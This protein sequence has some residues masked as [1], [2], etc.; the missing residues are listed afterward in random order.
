MLQIL[1]LHNL[2]KLLV[3]IFVSSR[4][5]CDDGPRT[6]LAPFSPGPRRYIRRYIQCSGEMF[7]FLFWYFPSA[8]F[9]SALVSG[10]VSLSPKPDRYNHWWKRGREG[11]KKDIS[12]YHGGVHTS[13]LTLGDLCTL[14]ALLLQVLAH[15]VNIWLWEEAGLILWEEEG[16]RGHCLVEWEFSLPLGASFLASI[17]RNLL[18]KRSLS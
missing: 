17:L 7:S 10:V 9:S 13:F 15:T 12:S 2:K 8:D 5:S 4:F 3:Y 1:N 6:S 16:Q 14:S 18:W 11:E